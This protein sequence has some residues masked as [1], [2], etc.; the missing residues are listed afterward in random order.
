[1]TFRS[2]VNT[3]AIVVEMSPN[4]AVVSIHHIFRG[5]GALGGG[6]FWRRDRDL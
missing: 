1:M 2:F 4:G 6:V 3:V 5:L